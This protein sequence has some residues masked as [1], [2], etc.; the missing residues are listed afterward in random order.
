MRA[1]PSINLFGEFFLVGR[2]IKFRVLIVILLFI[3]IILSGFYSLYL[4]SVIY[5]GK[6][7][8]LERVIKISL[9]EYNL[10]F[11]HLIPLI[12]YILNSDLFLFLII[13]ILENRF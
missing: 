12:I 7:F 2:L 9:L 11:Y 10:I 13:Y 5:H 3:I 4:F 1:P 6:I 8:F